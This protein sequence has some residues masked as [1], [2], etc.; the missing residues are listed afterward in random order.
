VKKAK[1]EEG[2][3]YRESERARSEWVKTEGSSLVSWGPVDKL[4]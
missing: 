4:F 1:S 3:V 2:E